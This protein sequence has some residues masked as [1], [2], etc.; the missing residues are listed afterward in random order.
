MSLQF[1][2]YCHFSPVELSETKDRCEWNCIKS[3]QMGLPCNQIFLCVCRF[4][5][6]HLYVGGFS[7]IWS[8]SG[9][10]DVQ[11]KQKEPT[12][13]TP[14]TRSDQC[15]ALGFEHEQEQKLSHTKRCGLRAQQ[16]ASPQWALP[17][18]A[19]LTSWSCST[20]V[21]IAITEKAFF[22]EPSY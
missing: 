16:A 1:A 6:Q 21:Q 3:F 22:H 4:S 10:L 8:F 13:S 15:F 11:I 14:T 20:F 17:P 18:P 5:A 12:L 2:G 9:I 19:A 7:Y